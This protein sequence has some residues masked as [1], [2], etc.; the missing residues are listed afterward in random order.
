[1]TKK[2][3]NA[4]ETYQL[5]EA[6]YDWAVNTFARHESKLGVNIKVHNNQDNLLEQGQIF[7]FNH[8]ARFEVVIPPYIL[9]RATGAYC[10][11]IADYRLFHSEKMSKMLIRCGAVPNNIPG[12]LPFMAAEILRGRKVMIFPE[13]GMIKDRR[14]TNDAGELFIYSGYHDTYRKHHKGAAVLGVLL[15]IFKRRIRDVYAAGDTRRVEHWCKSLGY[16]SPEALL[17]QAEKPTMIVPANMTF[18]PIRLTDTIVSRILDKLGMA[19][20][21]HLEEAIIES[22][23]LLRNTDMDIRLQDPV[24]PDVQWHWW[25]R[26]LLKRYFETVDEL[27]E[28]FGLRDLKNSVTERMFV[29]ALNRE[30][31]R[32][33]DACMREMYNGVTVNLAHLAAT[34]LDEYYAIRQKRVAKRELCELLYLAVK[35]VQNMP[36][37]HL[38]RG[39]TWPHRY[40]G[41][42]QSVSAELDEFLT[43]CAKAE[44]MEVGAEY[45]QLLDKM[46]G[47][48][49]REITRS[50]N[51]L[52]VYANEVLPLPHLTK[53]L[54]ELFDKRHKVTKQQVAAY[55]F[56]D[57]KRAYRWQKKYYQKP[58]FNDV[59]QA[60][61][62]K[63]KAE[64]FW[65]VPQKG[66]KVG[67]LLVHGFLSS[68]AE[69]K[70]YAQH[71]HAQ[72][73]S[74][75]AMRLPGHGT[76]PWE[77]HDT[78][79][80]AW[81]EAVRRNYDILSVTVERVVIVGYSTGGAL[82]LQLAA[83]YP[84]RLAGIAT[85]A[86]PLAVTDGNIRYAP[87][88]HTFNKVAQTFTG[89][90]GVA[91]FHIDEPQKP[92]TTY[93]HIPVAALTELL[94]VM[95]DVRKALTKVQVPLLVV[96]GKG[97]TIVEPESAQHIYDSVASSDKKLHWIDTE[98]H[99]LIAE[100]VADT[101]GQVDAFIAHAAQVSKI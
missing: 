57:E 5:D 55:R 74:V 34:L 47:E 29:R 11:S 42:Q 78:P 17:A 54:K 4:M 40:E 73:Y 95:K 20:G 93:R 26:Q 58:R 88:V 30:T 49:D 28:L 90:G 98:A 27:D 87:F 36:N 51:P 52:R 7:L 46:K 48:F 3:E 84:D 66:A 25:E 10:R 100:N 45:M 43:S 81:A 35:R 62:P 37:V 65:L 56:D 31:N 79:S 12:L 64:P 44:I 41:L 33:R 89:T 70:S 2:N 91:P 53:A 69:L 22:N 97:D 76:S 77:L 15:E 8:F 9:H 80:G 101:W 24:V 83:A 96:Q 23:I 92:E 68:N 6:F 38:H 71:L 94:R 1:M 32:V 21:R 72:G 18:Y 39:I 16:G 75:L 13:G 19:E 85:V 61:P 63:E 99:S 86:A 50:N 67:V 60:E 14:V 59:N 82:G